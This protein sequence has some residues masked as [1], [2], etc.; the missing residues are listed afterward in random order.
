MADPR[1]TGIIKDMAAIE[2]RSFSFINMKPA[3]NNTGLFPGVIQNMDLRGKIGSALQDIYPDIEQVG[4]VNL[5]PECAE[6][7][8]AGG[9]FCG[10][11][12]RSTAWLALE[13]KPGEIDIKVSGV[14]GNLRAGVT[15]NGEAF[16]QMPIYAEP[17]RI[18]PDPEHPGNTTVEMEGMTHYVDFNVDQIKGLTNEEIK[19]KARAEMARRGLDQGPACGIIYAEQTGDSWTIYPVVLVTGARGNK[20]ESLYY[21][22]ACGSGTTALG[23][24]LA[25][26]E[27]R[28]IKDVP[29]MQPSGMPIKFSVQ[30]DG[31]QFGYAQISGPIEKL[32][33]GILETT[34]GISYAVEQVASDEDLQNALQ[35]HGLRDAYRDAFGRP[36]YNEV[37]PDKQIDAMFKDYLDSGSIFVAL[38]EGQIIAFS[39]TQ[40][41]SSE[42]EVGQI[43]TAQAGIDPASWYIPD[44]GVRA[45]YENRG[46]GRTLMKRAL[47]VIPGDKPVTLRTAVN[48]V[49][50]QRLYT[51]LGFTI[52]PDLYQSK[53]QARTNGQEATD[54]RLFMVLNRNA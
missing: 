1:E 52:V 13:G 43:L 37:F 20:K 4:F 16:A 14:K 50:S 45:A 22:T 31:L 48:N 28:S 3:G 26:R 41:L 19:A 32:N 39:A 21:E 29:I 15:K 36:P 7:M 6:L 10:N 46:I 49:A 12:T 38:A 44:L 33:T 42:P 23:L 27:G 9:E 5:D 51:K 24:T 17:S 40:P 8:M 35:N 53:T 34:K 25:K 54:Q 2:G 11:A 47:D 30:Y 18:K